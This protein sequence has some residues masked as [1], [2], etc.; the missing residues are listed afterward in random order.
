M[1]T[2]QL[3][4]GALGKV[5]EVLIVYLLAQMTVLMSVQLLARHFPIITGVFWAEELAR[6]SMVTMI[7]LG[8]AV[9][10]RYKEHIAMPLLDEVLKGK[11][12]IVLKLVV[13]LLSGVF[14]VILIRYGFGILPTIA[15]Q[16]SATMQMP[17]NYVYITIPIGACIMLF[18]V[19]VEILELSL[20]LAGK[21]E[22]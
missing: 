21:G 14:L 13:S 5:L 6:Y 12:R 3:I 10:C 19:L 1:K 17:M 15:M 7:F 8:A 22:K 2:I 16:V 11:A 20:E 18:Y 9:S 4:S